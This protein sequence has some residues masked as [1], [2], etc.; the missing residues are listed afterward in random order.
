MKIS[1][2]RDIPRIAGEKDLLGTDQYSQALE[3]F[4]KLSDTPMTIA[5]QGEWGS[6]KTSMMNQIKSNLCDKEQLFYSVWLN[7]WQY[8]LFADESVAM[9]KIIKGIFD[10]VLEVIDADKAK[11]KEAVIAAKKI[12]AGLAKGAT[13]MGA[14]MVGAGAVADELLKS[15]PGGE[16]QIPSEVTVNDLRREL[17]NA[18]K[19]H[20]AA[21]PERK[22]FLIFIDDLDRIDPIAAVNILELLK[23]IFD[24]ENC[25]FVLAID[26]DVVVKGLKPKFGEPTPKNEREFRSFF[27][28]IIQL[29]FSMPVGSYKVDDFLID[30]LER[31]GYFDASSLDGGET[32][33]IV[34]RMSSLSVGRN[35]RA[36]KRLTNIL[37]LIKIFNQVSQEAAVQNDKDFEKIMNFG[38]ICLQL[39]YPP[40]YQMLLEEVD[41]EQ[42]SEAKAEQM[43]LEGIPEEV[44]ARLESM[45]TFDE[46]WE[47]FLF[48]F[49]QRDPYLQSNADNISQLLN[50]IKLQRPVSESRSLPE[51]LEGLLALSSVTQVEISGASG[52]GIKKGNKVF[53]NGIEAWKEN[54]REEGFV[55]VG[56][57]VTEKLH[58]SI[59]AIGK[60]LNMPLE[61]RYTGMMN[62]ITPSRKKAIVSTW[63]TKG[64]KVHVVIRVPSHAGMGKFDAERAK[65]NKKEDEVRLLISGEDDYSSL[66]SGI[67]EAV[68][69]AFN[70]A[71]N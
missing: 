4:I 14:G 59:Q 30:S 52:Q 44:S 49:C 46:E 6:G 5:I 70:I 20:V 35:P 58:D 47:Q 28:K 29:P 26:Y 19:E 2:I 48:R 51:I 40:V 62:F 55:E 60:E 71:D 33:S 42:W 21:N 45:E 1:N 37:S 53:L 56:L 57:N 32:S 31:I 38:L 34:S 23:N 41:F 9:L 27:D 64:G 13:R 22:G 10:Q 25:L 39:A 17:G 8:S 68:T 66:E 54:K 15:L 3:E 69:L 7:T 24:I 61:V 65:P 18:I 11:P 63:N 67:Q 16:G 50:L 12:F 43:N 36:M